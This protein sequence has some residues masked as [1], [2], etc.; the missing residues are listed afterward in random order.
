[1]WPSSPRS[2]P[3]TKEEPVRPPR[4]SPEAPAIDRPA[5]DGRR[6]RPCARKHRRVARVPDGGRAFDG[7]TLH[8][9]AVV[10]LRRA[11]P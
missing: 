2:V 1:M 4:S 7:L 11:A 9:R 10:V 3:A 6:A 5:L 8:R